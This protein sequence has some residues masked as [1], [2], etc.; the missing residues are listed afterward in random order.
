AQA[1]AEWLAASPNPRR[2]AQVASDAERLSGPLRAI[3]LARLGRVEEARAAAAATPLD[4][5]PC[6]RARAEAEAA[7]G[8][9]PAAD[10]WY[11]RAAALGPQLPLTETAWGA[12]LL[13]KGDARAA[14]VK[15]SAAAA[16][17]P[18]YADPLELWGEAL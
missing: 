5:A 4:C 14:I 18:R 6:L 12:S 8:N 2:R 3:A 15:L 16:K 10:G 11:A 9:W 13:A 7:A 17:G 1:D